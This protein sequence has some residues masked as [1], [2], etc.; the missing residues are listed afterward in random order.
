L[1]G[2]RIGMPFTI[3][4]I[5]AV[6]PLNYKG[7]VT[8]ALVVGSVMPD[9]AYFVHF[10]GFNRYL[11][12]SIRGL[13]TFCLPAGLAI[14]L[15]FQIFAR[16]PLFALLPASHQRRLLPYLQGFPYKSWRLIIRSLVSL[17]IGTLSH[18]AWDSFTHDHGFIVQNVAPLRQAIFEIDGTSIYAFSILQHGSTVLG[19]AALVLWYLGWLRKNPVYPFP[20]PR[21]LH[22]PSRTRLVIFTIMAAGACFWGAFAGFFFLPRVLSLYK[23][24]HMVE[25]L[26][27]V[28][29]TILCMEIAIYCVIWHLFPFAW[30]YSKR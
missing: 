3:S 6:I 18:L 29:M 16:R 24:R 4:H 28:S 8:S 21:S 2:V 25:F 5:A 15:V 22:L 10:E 27:V 23:L 11:G 30:R 26:A 12:H 14:W 7:L 19:L 1:K 9:L 17:G 13:F 20:V